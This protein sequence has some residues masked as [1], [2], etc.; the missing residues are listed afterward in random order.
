MAAKMDNANAS[1][2]EQKF[3]TTMFKYLPK[4]IDM[5][6]E[7]FSK[8]M[9]YKDASVAKDRFGQIRRKYAVGQ[10][11]TSSST[12]PSKAGVRKATKA[13]ASRKGR[14]KKQAAGFD[15]GDDDDEKKSITKG[16][17]QDD[18]KE[19]TIKGDRRRGKNGSIKKEAV[20][21]DEN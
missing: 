15:Y 3:F 21:D 2:A 18:E 10:P 14:A 1:S 12:S 16:G 8:E 19:K 6:W 4:G 5:D 9:G 20:S 17:S 11:A 13:K 7:E